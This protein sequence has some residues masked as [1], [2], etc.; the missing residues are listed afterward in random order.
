MDNS[1]LTHVRSMGWGRFTYSLVRRQDYSLQKY[2][3]NI[4]I[5]LNPIALRKVKTVY[6]LGLSDCNRVKT[7]HCFAVV[8]VSILITMF[9]KWLPLLES[10]LERKNLSNSRITRYTYF[11]VLD[12]ISGLATYFRFSFRSF[13]KGS[14]QLLAK[15]CAR[16]T[17]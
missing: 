14:C 16:S 9:S 10:V 12:S 11:K 17:G 1:S 7:N 13:K 6:N 4:Y 5:L 3:K 15:V 2:P 8:V